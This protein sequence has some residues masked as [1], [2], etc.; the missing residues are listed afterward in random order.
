MFA[1]LLSTITAIKE[2]LLRHH[3]RIDDISI[4]L[5][6]LEAK[7]DASTNSAHLCYNQSSAYAN[8]HTTFTVYHPFYTVVLVRFIDTINNK[9]ITP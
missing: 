1:F 4:H 3:T 5:Q 8:A 2:Q 7:I 6:M 9:N